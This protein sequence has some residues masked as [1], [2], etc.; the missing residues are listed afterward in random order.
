MFVFSVILLLFVWW[1][2]HKW[3]SRPTNRLMHEWMLFERYYQRKNV[4]R[5]IGETPESYSLRVAQHFPKLNTQILQFKE[6]WMLQMYNDSANMDLAA[7]GRLKSLRRNA[8]QRTK[9]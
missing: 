7:L 2:Y 8:C 1:L 4:T 6:A 3:M 5:A 9:N